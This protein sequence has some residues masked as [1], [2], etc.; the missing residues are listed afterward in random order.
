VSDLIHVLTRELQVLH[1][2]MTIVCS[3]PSTNSSRKCIGIVNA[4]NLSG[5]CQEKIIVTSMEAKTAKSATDNNYVNWSVI[6]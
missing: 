4:S 6:R 5:G 1:S 3:S 2:K